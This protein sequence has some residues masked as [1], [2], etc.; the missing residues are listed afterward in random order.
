M[1]AISVMPPMP[2]EWWLRPVSN[3]CRVGE[4]TAVVWNRLNR[5]PGA[6]SRSKVG[7]VYGPPNALDAPNL[8][9]SS[10]ITKTL[11][12]P[13]GGRSGVIGGWPCPGPSRRRS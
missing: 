11:G 7:V 9:S 5:S 8:V 6:A 12:A 2:T 3:A 4:H 13:F 1:V 10:M